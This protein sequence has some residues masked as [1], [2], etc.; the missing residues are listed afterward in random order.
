MNVVIENDA[1]VRAATR[2]T[3]VAFAGSGWGM[4]TWATRIPQVRDGLELTPSRLGLVLL[5]IAA[6]SII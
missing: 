4:S 3:Y 2:A 5:A 6:G 1:R